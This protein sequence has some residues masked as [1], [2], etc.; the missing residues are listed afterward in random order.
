MNL[1]EEKI[2]RQKHFSGR[3]FTVYED[4]VR[5]PDGKT[6]NREVVQHSGGVM[7]APLTE[8]SELLFVRQF[9][10]PY[11]K[12]ILEFPAGKLEPGEDPLNAGLRELREE[13]G[14]T[15]GRT[16]SLGEFYP[17]PGYC[18]ETI[19]MF[20]ALDLTLGEPN[21]DEG[22]FVEVVRIPLDEA[23]RMVL[24]NEIADGKTQT[25]ILKLVMLRDKIITN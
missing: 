25:A 16:F 14:A 21:P 15:A 8:S 11:G 1:F 17:T 19:Y 12:V 9:R 20:A 23:V 18:S 22:E 6:A 13:A 3:V 4:R 2:S 7:V 5:L 24:N 10:Y